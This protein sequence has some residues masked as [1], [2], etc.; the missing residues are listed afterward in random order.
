MVPIVR[1]YKKPM[2]AETQAPKFP[3]KDQQSQSKAN[4]YLEE[5][6]SNKDLQLLLKEL[7][8]NKVRIEDKGT[9]T[10]LKAL[11]NQTK[12]IVINSSATLQ[13]LYQILKR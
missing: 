7:M 2:N 3:S 13:V 11:Q 10:E 1:E 8:M 12:Q 6:L 4:G 5:I 9:Q